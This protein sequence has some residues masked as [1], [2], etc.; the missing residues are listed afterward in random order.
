MP[1]EYTKGLATRMTLTF[2][3]FEDVSL[4]IAVDGPEAASGRF[5]VT[6]E[7]TAPNAMSKRGDPFRR[8]QSRQEVPKSSLRSFEREPSHA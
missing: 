5:R 7:R 4:I 8:I 2:Q 1:T 6:R 3:Q